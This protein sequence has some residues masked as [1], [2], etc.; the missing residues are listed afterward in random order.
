M[1]SLLDT[2]REAM[3]AAPADRPICRVCGRCVTPRD[4]CMRLRGGGVV[5]CRCAAYD[6][7]GRRLISGRLGKR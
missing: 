5:H 7:P 4:Q 1:I 2:I 6:R 3:G